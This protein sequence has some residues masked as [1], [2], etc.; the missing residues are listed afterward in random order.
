MT[1]NKMIRFLGKSFGEL[2]EEGQVFFGIM[3]IMITV[4][5]IWLLMEMAGKK[6]KW[7]RTMLSLILVLASVVLLQGLA[8]IVRSKEA[9]L[10]ATVLA[11]KVG[12]IPAIGGILI[13]L[14]LGI[15]EYVIWKREKNIPKSITSQSVKETMDARTD[16]ICYASVE[17]QP[18]LVNRQMNQIC[19]K[20]F[21]TEILNL[22][23]FWKTLYQVKTSET[24]EVVR[25]EPTL[26]LRFSDTEVWNFRKK[27][28]VM[29]GN[30]YQE[31][32]AYDVSEE[33]QLNQELKFRNIRLNQVNERLMKF[34]E[35]VEEVTRQKEMLDAKMKVHDDLGRALIALRVYLAEPK[36]QKNREELLAMWKYIVASMEYEAGEK[37]SRQTFEALKEMAHSMGVEVIADGEIPK[38]EKEQQILYMLLREGLNNMLKHAGGH[39]LYLEMRELEEGLRIRLTNDGKVPEHKIVEKGGLK[40]LRSMVELAGG[41]FYVESF[42]AFAIYVNLM[43][44]KK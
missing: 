36:N 18:I 14:I 31:V 17:G 44:E 27:E 25:T 16:G 2:P 29:N 22:N 19:G 3:I 10:P 13:L 23:H 7:C 42:P 11:E 37:E 24:V 39:R 28:V 33:Y 1:E 9:S 12:R 43:R 4:F 6:R 40:N 34:N 20:L 38:S 41:T 8:D 32:I 5:S 21:Q 30:I 35:E 15:A 26:I